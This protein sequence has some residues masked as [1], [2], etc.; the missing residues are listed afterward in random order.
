MPCAVPAFTLPPITAIPTA[1]PTSNVPQITPSG[2]M[3]Q[4]PT[5]ALLEYA[6][7][8]L[9]NAHFIDC[10]IRFCLLMPRFY[11][12]M[13][14]MF[15]KLEFSLDELLPILATLR[16]KHH[17]E[18]REKRQNIIVDVG[19]NIGI[20]SGR[21]IDYFFDKSCKVSKIHIGQKYVYFLFSILYLTSRCR[22]LD[23]MLLS[24]EPGPMNFGGLS[25]NR[26][27]IEFEICLLCF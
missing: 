21:I 9:V 17:I 16:N 1:I 20:M 6:R 26:S 25:N 15:V 22:S 4:A 2:N 13:Y 10:C 14:N 12:S 7:R 11:F 24:F 19:A 5:P 3:K 18:I 23:N 27:V 8:I